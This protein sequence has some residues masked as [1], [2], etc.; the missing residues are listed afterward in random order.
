MN[1]LECCG[2][3]LFFQWLIAIVKTINTKIFYNAKKIKK[4]LRMLSFTLR[5]KK[6]AIASLYLT[7]VKSLLLGTLITS[8]P[9][10]TR[11]SKILTTILL[12]N[13]FPRNGSWTDT[14]LTFGT[15]R[16]SFY[17]TGHIVRLRRRFAK[18]SRCCI[19]HNIIL[20]SLFIFACAYCSN[21]LGVVWD[22]KFRWVV[23][24]FLYL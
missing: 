22:L 18:F 15:K 12:P 1:S 6:V 21:K 24:L 17:D 11:P 8:M 10:A 2:L 16:I 7:I 3:L 13:L 5:S 23:F 20:F 14:W 19:I 4:N 9:R